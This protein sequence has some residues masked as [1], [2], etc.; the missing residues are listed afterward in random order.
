MPEGVSLLD[1][2]SDQATLPPWMSAAH[3]DE[4]VAA[5]AA[6]GFK[7]PLDW[8][9]CLDRNWGLTAFLRGQKIAQPALFMVG[10]RDP[11]RHYAGPHEA[12]QKD[13][14]TD[15]RDQI[16]LRSAGH[17]LQQERADEVSAVLVEFLRGF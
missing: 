14:L 17:W 4:Y 15:L 16:V 13:W 10:E 2:I 9:R 12:A 11:V 7:G 8:Y 5:F 1:S 6:P 3:F